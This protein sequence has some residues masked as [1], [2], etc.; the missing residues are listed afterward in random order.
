MNGILCVCAALICGHTFNEIGLF[1][2]NTAQYD[3]GIA[4][5]NG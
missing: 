3:V 5:I 2:V 4:H 1:F